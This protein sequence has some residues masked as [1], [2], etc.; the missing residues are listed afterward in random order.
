MIFRGDGTDKNFYVFHIGANGKY[1][2]FKRVDGATIKLIPRWIFS[3]AIRQGFNAWNTLK[4]VCQ[5]ST[6]E[7]YINGT[8]VESLVD[9]EFSTGK[10]GVRAV[11]NTSVQNIMHFDNARL[12]LDVGL[13]GVQPKP[14][15]SI[16][17]TVE[18]S[19]VSQ[20]EGRW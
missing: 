7:F 5:G 13:S 19:E 1:F 20:Q 4:V 3:N 8:Q 18:A 15:L 12:T 9:S 11:E 10:V 14:A 16:P 17:V 2:I 6:L